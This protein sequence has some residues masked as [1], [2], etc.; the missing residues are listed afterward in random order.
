M[1]KTIDEKLKEG[2]EYRRI[3]LEDIELREGETEDEKY[4][5]EGYATKFSNWYTLY[6]YGR[7][8]VLESIDP[9]AFDK[10]DMSDVIMQY[11]HE[12][13][14]F[15]RTTN[16]TLT[17]II[18]K[19][20]LK[21]RAYLGGTE[22]G[23][24]LFEEIKGKYISKMSFGFVVSTQ[25]RKV[26]EDEENDTE[27]VYRTITGISK[28]YDVSAVSIPANDATEISSRT[29]GEGV[30]AEALQELEQAKKREEQ[31]KKLR[32]MCAM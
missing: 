19:I 7:Y 1:P 23:R 13:R 12:G 5:V 24:Q 26:V 32:I 16:A 21:I 18:D 20:G 4:I 22:G 9:H 29:L 17:L 28:L 25:E 10:C 27:T 15:A 3:N 8:T 31:R 14:V 6:K 30:I 2:R 11:D